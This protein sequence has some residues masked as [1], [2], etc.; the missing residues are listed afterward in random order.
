MLNDILTVEA[1]KPASHKK[2]GV[3]IILFFFLFDKG[4]IEFTDEVIKVINN[5]CENIIFLLWVMNN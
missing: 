3:L 2:S 5:E 1:D 4:W